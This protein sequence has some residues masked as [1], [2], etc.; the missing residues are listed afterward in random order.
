MPCPVAIDALKG[1]LLHLADRPTVVGDYATFVNLPNDQRCGLD[2]S[3]GIRKDD[4]ATVSDWLRS[5][6]VDY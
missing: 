6:W 2:T 3:N 4:L 5:S 1:D